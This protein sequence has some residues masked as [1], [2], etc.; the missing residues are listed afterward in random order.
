MKYLL[1]IAYDGS[2]YCGFQKQNNGISVQQVLTEAASK[3]FGDCKI[4]GCS[5]TDSGVHALG[6][7]AT[8]ECNATEIPE[9]KV[10]VAMNCHLPDDIS[11]LSSVIAP[12]DFHPRYS[13]LSKEYRYVIHNSTVRDPFLRGRAYQYPKPLDVEKMN[14]AASY[15]V[16]EHDF[17]SFMASGSKITDTV[18]NI[19]SCEVISDGSTVTVCI[20]G[21]GFLYNMVRIIVG[22]LIAVS[23]GRIKPSD[24][25]KILESRDRTNAG[26]TV[27]A[28]GLYLYNVEY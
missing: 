22:T 26:S 7:K 20:K 19:Y 23:E 4:T 27:P 6:F 14:E 1:T 13:V 10:A 2:R 24:I 15:L 8:L 25:Q 21:N 17:A 11:V 28:C 16:G 9:N 5:R 12:D 18:R 3:A